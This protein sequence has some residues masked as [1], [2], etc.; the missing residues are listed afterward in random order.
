[1][2]NNYTAKHAQRSGAGFHTEDNKPEPDDGIIAIK[3]L[4]CGEYSEIMD[5]E[6]NC[7]ECESYLIV[8]VMR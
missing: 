7:P 6:I 8:E 3:C 5:E 1:M 4:T 2:K